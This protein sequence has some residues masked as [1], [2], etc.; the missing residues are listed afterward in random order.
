MSIFGL[1]GRADVRY[2]GTTLKLVANS[3]GGPPANTSGIAINNIG[4][5]GVGTNTPQSTFHVNG[6]SWFQGDTSPLPPGAGKGIVV[7]FSGEQGYISAFDYGAFT[8][9]NLL[10]NLGGGNVGIGTTNPQ[11]KLDVAGTIKTNILQIT[12]GSDLAEKFEVAADVS[13]AGKKAGVIATKPGMVMAIDPA[14]AEV[15]RVCALPTIAASRA[16]SAVLTIS[17]PACCCPI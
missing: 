10:L 11:A 8:P 17:R 9:K 7:G 5:V 3:G 14:C 2:D 6:S 4:R 1:I 12:G 16:L 15:N 13:N